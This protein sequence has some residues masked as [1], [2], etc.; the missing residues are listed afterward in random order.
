MR[1]PR[2]RKSKPRA[3][4]RSGDQSRRARPG[5]GSPGARCQHRGMTGRNW[6][7]C[8]CRQMLT[9][10]FRARDVSLPAPLFDVAVNQIAA[11]TYVPGEPLVSVRGGGP[12][13]ERKPAISGCLARSGWCC[14]ALLARVLV[15]AQVA[16]NRVQGRAISLV[17]DGQWPWSACPEGVSNG[18]DQVWVAEHKPMNAM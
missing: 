14:G 7:A 5:C 16:W 12:A 11:G 9:A 4:G 3:R 13:S 8:G 1:S 2:R 18:Q 15:P 10:E 6:I 17:G